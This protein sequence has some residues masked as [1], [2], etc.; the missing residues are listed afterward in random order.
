MADA[1]SSKTIDFIA[2]STSGLMA[3]ISKRDAEIERL[4]ALVT[5]L[6]NVAQGMAEDRFDPGAEA[7][8]AIHCGRHFIY[9]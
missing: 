9:D 3:E 2:M 1:P 7:M 8:A 6:T 4:R 5:R